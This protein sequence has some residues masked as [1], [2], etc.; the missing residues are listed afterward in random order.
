MPESSVRTTSGLIKSSRS[1]V[2]AISSGQGANLTIVTYQL[3]IRFPVAFWA[4]ISRQ[5]QA[6]VFRFGKTADL[7]ARS[8][9]P[10][11]GFN[12]VL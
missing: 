10:A 11:R 2:T 6:L 7:L 12:I 3:P 4:A 1:G 8:D 5:L 9:T